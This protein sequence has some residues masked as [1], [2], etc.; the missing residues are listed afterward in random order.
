[1]TIST[2]LTKDI[3]QTYYKLVTGFC[4]FDLSNKFKIL[5]I[6]T[7]KYVTSEEDT[8]RD[9]E[10]QKLILIKTDQHF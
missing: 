2:F 4:L 10:T 6:S 9:L 7:D 5:V 1:M 3:R 8:M